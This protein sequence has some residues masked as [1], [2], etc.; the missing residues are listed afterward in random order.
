MNLIKNKLIIITNPIYPY[1][2]I[3]LILIQ[4]LF[5]LLTILLISVS[6]S[7]QNYH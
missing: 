1:I 5:I 6:Y 3:E 7:F 2:Y 4:D